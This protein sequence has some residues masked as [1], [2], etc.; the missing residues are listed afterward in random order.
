MKST[1]SFSFLASIF[2]LRNFP[3]HL[4]KKFDSSF[5]ASSHLPL[6]QKICTSRA[7]AQF[8]VPL[9]AHLSYAF[10]VLTSSEFCVF[11]ADNI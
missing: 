5:H 3:S 10:A 9:L 11:D 8:Y 2:C 1:S 7:R 4:W 6:H